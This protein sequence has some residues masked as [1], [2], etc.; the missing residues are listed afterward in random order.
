MNRKGHTDP[1]RNDAATPKQTRTEPG[2]P[3]PSSTRRPATVPSTDQLRERGQRL[4]EAIELAEAL[5]TRHAPLLG[6]PP[7][8]NLTLPR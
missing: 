8:V 6:Y 2:L 7:L 3:Q 4:E 5:P 1:V